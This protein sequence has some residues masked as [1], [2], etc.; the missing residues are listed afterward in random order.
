[1]NSGEKMQALVIDKKESFKKNSAV[2]FNR[3]T[4]IYHCCRKLFQRFN[5][6]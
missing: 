3:G 5:F 4:T 6:L 1:M 2:I